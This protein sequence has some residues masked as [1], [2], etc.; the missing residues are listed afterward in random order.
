MGNKWGKKDMKRSLEGFKREMTMLAITIMG[1]HTAILAGTGTSCQW[2][3][4]R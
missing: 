4:W 1:T 3:G 2:C